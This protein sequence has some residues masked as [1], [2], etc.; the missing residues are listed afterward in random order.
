MND[1]QKA[2]LKVSGA[3][4]KKATSTFTE[5]TMLPLLSDG[6]VA[7]YNEVQQSSMVDTQEPMTDNVVTLHTDLSISADDSGITT[8]PLVTLNAIWA[9]AIELLSTSNA[10]TPAPGSQK[11]ACMVLS[12][13]QVAPHLIQAKSDEQYICDSNCQQWISS[14]LCSH[15]LAVAERNDD[16]SF[17]LQWYTTHA[18]RPNI[19]TLAM[20]NL[21]RGRGRKGGRAKRQR[22]RSYNPPIDNVTV[23][24]GLQTAF[25]NNNDVRYGTLVNVSH[26]NVTVGSGS[27]SNIQVFPEGCV[28]TSSGPP[29]LIRLQQV[30]SNPFFVKILAG[31]I[32]VCQGCRGSLRL[33]NGSVPQPPF[34]LVI[35][36]MEKRSYCDSSGILRTPSRPSAAHY[37]LKLVCVRAI[38]PNFIPTVESFQIPNDIL[39][40]LT[41]Q[42]RQHIHL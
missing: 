9:K 13:S 33:T 41:F 1:F 17:F 38:E 25:M 10:I 12:Y 37:H 7:V 16:L 8:I 18:K 20:S 3:T 36:R 31:N 26:D 5:M 21:P 34:D 15:T 27:V 39:P 23:R 32:R 35:A 24:P 2:T 30:S 22:N 29:P 19:S 28:P 6:N 11:K 4:F 14:Q 42:H 40:L